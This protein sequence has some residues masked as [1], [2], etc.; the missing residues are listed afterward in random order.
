MLKGHEGVAMYYGQNSTIAAVSC[1]LM[2]KAV[3]AIPPRGLSRQRW[4][5]LHV[6][7]YYAI[8]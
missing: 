4:V 6:C 7:I 2:R 8:F 3:A 1:N 5:G